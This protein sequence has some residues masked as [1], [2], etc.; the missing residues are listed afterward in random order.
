MTIWRRRSLQGF[1]VAL[2]FSSMLLV[3]A[4]ARP[5]QA[6]TAPIWR[7][8]PALWLVRDADTQIFIFGTFHVLPQGLD[9]FQGRVKAAFEKS[10]TLV[11]EAVLPDDPI[12]LQPLL[13]RLGLNP[14][15]VTLSSLLSPELKSRLGRV[16]QEMGVN[17]AVFEIFQPWLAS[18][19]IASAGLMRL[20]L[21][22]ATGVE[23]TLKVAARTSGKQ[24]E[25]L[26]SAEEQFGFLASLPKTEQIAML[27]A[28]LDDWQS[29]KTESG[30]MIVSWSRG[31]IDTVG[32]KMNESLEDLPLLSK[33]LLAD[34]NKRWAGWIQH[35]L[36]QPG[37]VF[38]AVGAGHLAGKESLRS[39]LTQR[40][41]TIEI[42]Q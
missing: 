9:W 23:E 37:R 24:I 26:E 42:I 11:I 41:I 21:N 8:T 20:G 2:S 14:T 33:A 3:G 35:R 32:R 36:D 18:V 28:T 1:M 25:G 10:D 12:A 5:A 6:P 31:D 19:N 16:S 34:R 22:T 40:G 39:F 29:L 13:L 4:W 30:A 38:L 17:P 15:G 7:A 27:S